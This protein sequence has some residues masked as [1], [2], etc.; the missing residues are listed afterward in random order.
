[1]ILAASNKSKKLLYIKYIDTVNAGDISGNRAELASLMAELSAGFRLLADFSA[2]EK[3]DTDCAPEI[4]EV[5]EQLEQAGVSTVVR[6][7]PDPRKD[8]GMN[9][10]SL[11]HYKSPPRTTTCSSIAEAVKELSF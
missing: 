9:I 1:M 6:V 3:M 10:L 2:L 11:F 4:G 8:I 5:M 7:I